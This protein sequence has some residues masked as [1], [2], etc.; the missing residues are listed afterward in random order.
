LLRT[1]K[2]RVVNKKG[3]PV[4]LGNAVRRAEKVVLDTALKLNAP[5]YR[6]HNNALVTRHDLERINLHTMVNITRFIAEHFM[7]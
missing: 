3:V 6:T 1:S 5:V 7:K 2:G 4:L